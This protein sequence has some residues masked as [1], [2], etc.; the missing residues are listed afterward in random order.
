MGS[1]AHG[2]RLADM[3]GVS[4][5]NIEANLPVNPQNIKQR[6]EFYGQAI[7][8]YSQGVMDHMLGEKTKGTPVSDDIF[9]AQKQ[10]FDQFK[11][12]ETVHNKLMKM[13]FIGKD[14]AADKKFD[15]EVQKKLSLYKPTIGAIQRDTREE[16]K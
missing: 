12:M 2:L 1:E 6:L 10:M 9:L 4:K 15:D 11:L 13:G 14:D 7:L 16:V 8:A 3:D 5:T